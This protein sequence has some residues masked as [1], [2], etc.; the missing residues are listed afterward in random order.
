MNE[1][2]TGQGCGCAGSGPRISEKL[3]GILPPE[4]ASAHFRNAGIE[5]LKGFRELI[6]HR[7]QTLSQDPT[8][9]TKV[10]VE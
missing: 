7:I 8:R 5:L 1:Q 4:S 9:G 10:N 6:D 2:A 3:R